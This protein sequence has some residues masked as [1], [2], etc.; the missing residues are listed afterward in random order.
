[1]RFFNENIS[2]KESLE[3]LETISIA[4]SSNIDKAKFAEALKTEHDKTHDHLKLFNRILVQLKLS[5]EILS[6]LEVAEVTILN[7]VR[8]IENVDT[9]NFEERVIKMIM[10]ALKESQQHNSD[11]RGQVLATLAK[12]ANTVGL[13]KISTFIEVC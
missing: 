12:L 2:S 13:A 5:E 4:D 3:C 1:M 9:E 10:P 11:V 6:A 8:L 7:K